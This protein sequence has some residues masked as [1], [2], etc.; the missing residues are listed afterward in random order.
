MLIGACKSP[1]DQTLTKEHIVAISKTKELTGEEVQ[2]L[3]AFVMRSA[4]ARAFS[5]ADTSQLLD[6]TKTIRTAIEEQRKW[7]HDDS[8]STA[9]AKAEAEA[10]VKRYELEIGRLRTVVTVTPVRKGFSEADYE[11]YI[12][13]QMVAKNN[14]DKPVS[15]FKGH[16]KVT[17][18]FGDLISR[19][20]IKQDEALAPDGE[21]VFRTSYGYNQFMDRDKKLRYTDYEKMKFIWEPEMIIFADGTQLAVPD[22]PA[23]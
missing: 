2:L 16:V 17:D 8:V 11:G 22:R 15:G 3:Q 20:E 18:M 12:T 1:R 4:L 6:S 14:G 5:G 13:F 10:A 7:R 23:P 21:K 9:S 19:L